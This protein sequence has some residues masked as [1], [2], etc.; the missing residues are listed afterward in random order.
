M[1]T[2]YPWP[3][4]DYH[5][6]DPQHSRGHLPLRWSGRQTGRLLGVSPHN[7]PALPHGRLHQ[8]SPR[9]LSTTV[10]IGGLH[11]S[12]SFSKL[13]ARVVNYQ[14]E[15][16]KLRQPF[17]SLNCRGR[18]VPQITGTGPGSASG[19]SLGPQPR[20]PPPSLPLSLPFSPSTRAHAHAPRPPRARVRNRPLLSPPLSLSRPH[21][22]V[23][24]TR[25]RRARLR[26]R[27]FI[28]SF[29]SRFDR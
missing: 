22:R 3:V 2:D 26:D 16:S 4:G 29:V 12:P 23:H 21:V 20:G 25:T 6:G 27:A 18:V 15:R 5:L 9:R 8:G 10:R 19:R 28:F 7:L 11:Q 17:L 13:P 1:L 14:R 24:P